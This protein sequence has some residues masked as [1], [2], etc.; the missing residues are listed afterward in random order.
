MY[1]TP[2][3]NA[4]G[5][6]PFGDANGVGGY[7]FGCATAQQYFQ[8]TSA[9]GCAVYSG[10]SYVNY[11]CDGTMIPQHCPAALVP[12]PGA[13]GLLYENDLYTYSCGENPYLDSWNYRKNMVCAYD[14]F[15]PAGDCF[16][17]MQYNGCLPDISSQAFSPDINAVFTAGTPTTI[18]GDKGVTIDS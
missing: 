17:E 7:D 14:D 11:M 4:Y 8:H 9:A 18:P 16:P 15:P 6:H 10:S 2:F 13:C 5:I 3:F 1:D 12:D